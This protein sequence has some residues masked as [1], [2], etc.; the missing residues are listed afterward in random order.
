MMLHSSQ[1]HQI[2]TVED[3]NKKSGKIRIVPIYICNVSVTL[4]RSVPPG[5]HRVLLWLWLEFFMVFFFWFFFSFRNLLEL[6]KLQAQNTSFNLP[7]MLLLSMIAVVMLDACEL[8]SWMHVVSMSL[9]A[10]QPKSV[11]ILKTLN[12]VS[13][14]LLVLGLIIKITGKD[15][16]GVSSVALYIQWPTVIFLFL[17]IWFSNINGS[18]KYSSACWPV[19]WSWVC[20]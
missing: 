2:W 1:V 5:F 4:G 6:A 15:W 20:S 14:C 18:C 8:R 12:W 10:S 17:Y 11:V 19:Q 7:H 13:C 16:K 9:G 3:N